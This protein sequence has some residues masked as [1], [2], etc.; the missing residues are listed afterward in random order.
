MINIAIVESDQTQAKHILECL[1]YVTEAD[2]NDFCVTQFSSPL[3]FFERFEQFFDLVILDTSLPMMDGMEVARQLRK[4]NKD[5][6]IVFVSDDANLAISG[7]EVS[8]LD[9]I[10]KPLSK[11]DFYQRMKRLM[12]R[13]R[14]NLSNSILVNFKDKTV[15]FSVGRIIYLET[16]GHYIVYHTTD[17]N[18]E[19]YS[20]MKKAEN[21]LK[22]FGTFIKCNQCY[23]VNLAYAEQLLGDSVIVAGKR[24][25]VSRQQRKAFAAAFAEYGDGNLRKWR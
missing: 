15:F 4:V 10:L 6:G 16:Q 12:P 18:F 2:G 22:R 17:G 9:F 20:T 11:Q 13:V 21:S 3:V 5:I 25:A 19:E 14:Q 1:E 8:A 7:Y 24:L 23:L